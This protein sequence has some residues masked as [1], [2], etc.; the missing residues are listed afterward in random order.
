MCNIKSE[1]I[2]GSYFAFNFVE[3]KFTV[4]REMWNTVL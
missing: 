2:I 3:H 1:V 4:N